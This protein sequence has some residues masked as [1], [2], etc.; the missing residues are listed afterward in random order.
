[1]RTVKTYCPVGTI[2]P[3]D[4]FLESLEPKLRRKLYWQIFQ[5]THLHPTELKEPHYK[6]FSLEKYNQFYELREKSKIL[7][8]IIFTIQGKDVILLEPFIKR[9]S[10]DTMKA[11]DQ[12]LKLLAE[13]Q[14]HPEYIVQFQFK[15][16]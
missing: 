2:A 9:Q 12:S 3:M 6:H 1:M 14:E 11:L 16:E 8:R 10:R 4:T 7:V 5:L 15:G 13:I